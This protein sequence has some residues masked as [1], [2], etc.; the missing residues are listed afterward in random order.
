MSDTGADFA[1]QPWNIGG[2]KVLVLVGL[3]GSG[4]STFAKELERHM[5]QFRRCN[6]DDL[7]NR[8][9]VEKLAR[10]SLHDGLSVC[11]D[12]TN[13]DETQRAHWINIAR[14][15]PGTQ[16]WC[17]VC[18]DHPTIKNPE[19]ARIIL[20]RFAN[21]LRPPAFDEGFDRILRIKPADHPSLSYSQ[22]DISTILLKIYTSSPPPPSHQGRAF[23]SRNQ[24]NLDNFLGGDGRFRG[25][26][27]GSTFRARGYRGRGY[28][29]EFRPRGTPWAS[30]SGSYNVRDEHASSRSSGEPGTIPASNSGENER[31]PI[32]RD[33]LENDE[34]AL[35]PPN[36]SNVREDAGKDLKDAQLVAK[37]GLDQVTEFGTAEKPI[38]LE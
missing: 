28:G 5:P 9:A 30:T 37:E 33:P 14:E 20:H 18:T 6:Q 36:V 32:N 12:R 19:Q 13:V 31:H 8:R 11:I 35:S 27:R 38:V 1:S 7:G 16:V 22:D 23:S 21:D 2:P 4:K 3:I 15:L 24:T 25:G 17:L 29:Q 26:Q 34:L 10:E